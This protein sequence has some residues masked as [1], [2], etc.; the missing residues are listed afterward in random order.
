MPFAK[1]LFENCI[2]CVHQWLAENRLR[3]N[4]DKTEEM[5]CARSGRT[6]LANYPSLLVGECVTRCSC[7]LVL[8]R[9]D[10]CNV[11]YANAPA[12]QMKRLQVLINMAARVVSGRRRFDPITDFIRSELHWLPVLERVQFKIC[13]MRRLISYHQCTF[14]ISLLCHQLLLAGV[15]CVRRRSKYCWYQDIEHSS[16]LEHSRSR[17]L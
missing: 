16:Q 8:S 12:T 14:Q 6:R 10:Y 7:A 2:N 3:L 11:L 1:L 13:I 17:D 4:S 5:W 9:L 15:I